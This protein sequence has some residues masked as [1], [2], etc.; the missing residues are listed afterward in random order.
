LERLVVGAVAA[1]ELAFV[2]LPEGRIGGWDVFRC[3]MEADQVDDGRF[4][5]RL[6]RP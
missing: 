5:P 2:V 1:G 3:E 4:G 6:M